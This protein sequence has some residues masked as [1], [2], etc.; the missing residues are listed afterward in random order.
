MLELE[1]QALGLE[2][3]E[4]GR[5]RRAFIAYL[6]QVPSGERFLPARAEAVAYMEHWE[7][8]NEWIR[9]SFFPDR[10]RLF[11]DDF[12]MYPEDARLE[13]DLP[14]EDYRAALETLWRLYA[15]RVARDPDA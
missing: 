1:S 13:E 12:G 2:R 7:E 14:A 5:V 15:A 6:E 8:E 4:G 11:S 9:E 10:P 3:R